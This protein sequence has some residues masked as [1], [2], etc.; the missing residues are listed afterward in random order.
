M[1]QRVQVSCINKRE[2]YNPHERIINIGGVNPN[3]N[4]WKRSQPKAIESIE[5]GTYDFF[6]SVGGYTTDVIVAR[7]EGHKYLKTKPDATG[8]DN[9][10]NLPECPAI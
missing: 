9:L 2:H 10:L 7:H 4:R 5:D 3:G 1:A 6:V 8:K